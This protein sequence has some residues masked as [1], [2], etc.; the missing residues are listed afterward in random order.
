MTLPHRAPVKETTL[1]CA[2]EEHVRAGDHL[3]F[4]STP[5]RSNAAVRQVARRFRGTSPEFVISTTGFHSTAHLLALLRLG[6]RY[7][8]CFFGDNYPTP[9]PNALYQ[10][11]LD[12][13][14][15]LEHWSLLSYVQSLRAAA[16]G[17]PFAVS[18]SL[19]GTSLGAQL[20]AQ[21]RYLEVPN[22]RTPAG[23]NPALVGLLQPLQPDVCFL[24]AAIGGANGAAC[25]FP[26]HSEGFH[27]ALAAKKGVIITVDHIV[28]S[29]EMQ[30]YPEWQ[31]VPAER[32]LAICHAPFGAHPQPVHFNPQCVNPQCFTLDSEVNRSYRDDYSHFDLWRRITEERPLFEQFCHRVLDS[33]DD[34]SAYRSFVGAERLTALQV[35]RRPS[36]ESN[37][38]H[39][40]HALSSRPSLEAAPPR[41]LSDNERLIV[42]GARTLLSL[43][44]EHKHRSVLAGIGLSFSAARLLKALL[45]TTGY[46]VEL[47]VETGFQDFGHG[48]PERTD[49]Y[50]LS[51]RNVEQSRRLTGIEQ[52]LGALVCGAQNRC[53]GVVGC[54]QIDPHAHL[55][56]TLVNGKLV[57]GSG[58]AADIAAGA[59]ELV[60]LAR[61]DR[62]VPQVEHVTSRA[63]GPTSVVTERGV[64]SRQPDG[65]W[66]FQERA[67]E[68]LA[69]DSPPEWS[70]FFS[71]RGWHRV[72]IESASTPH[73]SDAERSF[74]DTVRHQSTG[75]T[76]WPGTMTKQESVDA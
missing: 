3:H 40:D 21:G 14:A 8:A 65:S 38:P 53:V 39:I 71:E 61:L 30:R 28:S 50:L 75:A 24:H 45:L 23:S 41:S 31:T 33:D 66:A 32:V 5:S 26:P 56:S 2:I 69:A 17:S 68:R 20:A 36:D 52:T 11:L 72:H 57:V 27:A 62:L 74:L 7:I 47:L 60:V 42:L 9:R 13:G 34:D 44:I 15:E 22:P 43:A 59:R 73:L 46:D 51:Q 35:V 16:E 18:T 64:L 48:E 25:F 29:D 12:E 67:L 55:N 58:G 49:P 10:T 63:R 1:A 4:A 37:G 54:A 76:R 6:K 19:L 70:R